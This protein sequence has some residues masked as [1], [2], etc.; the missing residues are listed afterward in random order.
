MPDR[1]T[2]R[3]RMRHQ[4]S[5]LNP[6]ETDPERGLTDLGQILSIWRVIGI[7]L[8]GVGLGLVATA[9]TLDREWDPGQQ[10]VGAWSRQGPVESPASD[11]YR[12]ALLAATGEVSLAQNE[13]V[14]FQAQRDDSGYRLL[15][16][17][18]YRVAGPM[19]KARFWTL[20]VVDQD[21][22]VIDNPAQRYGFTSSNVV[23]DLS[24][25]VSVVLGPEARSG[26]WLPTPGAGPM[27]L[28]LRLYDT[29]LS[30]REGGIAAAI[31]PSIE[32]QSCG[33]S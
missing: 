2:Q 18:R 9:L 22:R 25:D 26:N 14:L 13:G 15:R 27:T 32:R 4:A 23:R 3:G 20:S 12:R 16:S 17:C 21:G 30:D 7:A 11:P 10:T 28:V 1:S 5:D 24:G 29:P 19:S 31:T 6:I 33:A 8:A